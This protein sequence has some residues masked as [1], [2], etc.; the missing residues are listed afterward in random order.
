MQR[1]YRNVLELMYMQVEHMTDFLAE[2]SARRA[3]AKIL[4]GTAAVPNRRVAAVFFA[5]C[6]WLTGEA[7]ILEAVYKLGNPENNRKYKT[8]KK[9]HG[10]KIELLY[11]ACFS[12]LG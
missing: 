8:L 10:R 2:R 11:H 6:S 3:L 4:V 7:D 1:N 5:R 9:K 12:E